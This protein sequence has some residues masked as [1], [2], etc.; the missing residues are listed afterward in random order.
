MTL[1][2]PRDA[3]PPAVA[4]PAPMPPLPAMFADL[5]PSV[6]GDKLRENAALNL[7]LAALWDWFQQCYPQRQCDVCNRWVDA[8]VHADHVAAHGPVDRFLA[9]TFGVRAR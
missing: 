5:P 8:R 4:I 3:S 9:R 7:G 6:I 2:V 1:P